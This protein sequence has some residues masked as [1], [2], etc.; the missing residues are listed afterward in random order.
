MIKLTQEEASKV[1]VSSIDES[2]RDNY[3]ILTFTPEEEFSV[4]ARITT[5][6]FD[7]GSPAIK[8][9]ERDNMIADFTF[10]ADKTYSVI[11]HRYHSSP[12]A[13]YWF[14]NNIWYQVL[15]S[16]SSGEELWDILENC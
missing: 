10:E 14:A 2:A 1:F 8:F 13:V 11:V 9:F 16:D 15:N 12:E 7:D 4:E 5:K 6:T 3:D